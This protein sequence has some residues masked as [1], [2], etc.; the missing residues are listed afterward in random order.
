[1]SIQGINSNQIRT[2]L[3][4]P[5]TFRQIINDVKYLTRLPCPNNN[6]CRYVRLLGYPVIKNSDMLINRI[7]S[8]KDCTHTGALNS[9]KKRCKMKTPRLA[10][11]QHRITCE[12]NKSRE[13]SL[14]HQQVVRVS[15]WAGPVHKTLLCVIQSSN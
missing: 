3:K 12:R 15:K 1:M 8:V 6:T 5:C 4:T 2:F 10:I 7:L 13:I 11:H 9:I 14:N